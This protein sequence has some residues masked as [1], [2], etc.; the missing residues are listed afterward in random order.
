MSGYVYKN[1]VGRSI[2]ISGYQF[3]KDGK[4]PSNIILDRFKEAVSNGFLSL[5]EVKDRDDPKA[6]PAT[7]NPEEEAKKAADT[8]KKNTKKV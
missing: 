4:L 8:I 1:E 5:R 3:Q 6:S 2:N 7:V